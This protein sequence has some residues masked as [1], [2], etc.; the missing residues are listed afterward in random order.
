MEHV[1]AVC[2]EYPESPGFS[3]TS[4]ARM[5]AFVLLLFYYFTDHLEEFGFYGLSEY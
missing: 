1:N 3:P 2:L 5:R 4:R